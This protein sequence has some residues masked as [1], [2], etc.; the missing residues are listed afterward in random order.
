MFWA[1]ITSMV[2]SLWSLYWLYC[3][4]SIY[5]ISITESSL[6][7]WKWSQQT[8][9][10]SWYPPMRLWYNKPQ[11]ISNYHPVSFYAV[12]HMSWLD[13]NS[14]VFSVFIRFSWGKTRN[15]SSSLSGATQLA[16]FILSH[17]ARNYTT[18]H[19]SSIPQHAQWMLAAREPKH[20]WFQP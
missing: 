14:P 20:K 15:I 19:Y 2:C 11:L 16:S 7:L 13:S 17:F 8:S 6:W 5:P 9:L 10:K 4:S 18:S 1:C 12:C 3:P